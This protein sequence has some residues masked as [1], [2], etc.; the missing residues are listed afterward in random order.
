MARMLA[1]AGFHWTGGMYPT[2]TQETDQTIWDAFGYVVRVVTGLESPNTIVE[3]QTVWP[4]YVSYAGGST[5]V[6]QIREESGFA[7]T[8]SCAR[9]VGVGRIDI[10]DL[11]ENLIGGDTYVDFVDIT[12]GR[13]WLACDAIQQKQF[14]YGA[15]GVI[16]R[17]D[18]YPYNS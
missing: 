14:V 13:V 5:P 9:I 2:I 6:N 10:A 1:F 4:Q 16:G 15:G 17:V 3:N 7:K 11:A 18:N 12:P 8:L